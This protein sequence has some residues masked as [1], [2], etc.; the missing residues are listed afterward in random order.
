MQV[1]SE[2]QA[3]S[4]EHWTFREEARASD[5]DA[6]RAIV[7]S[8]GFFRDYEIP[9]AVE[10][11]DE[12]LRDGEASGYLFTF[13]DTQSRAPAGYAC[14]GPISCTESSYD[15]YWIAVHESF[16]G[17]G[18]GGEILRHAE[19]AIRSRGGTRVYIETSGKSL[20][21]PTRRFYE[22]MGYRE[23]ARLASFYGPGDDKLIYSR[24]LSSGCP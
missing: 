10:L 12:R 5:R 23:E 16:R 6:V 7:E 22:R 17:R 20:Y 24:A 13:L 18:L 14:Y 2:K 15:L 21:E 4:A 19:K 11:V 1:G 8:T 9:V 3:A